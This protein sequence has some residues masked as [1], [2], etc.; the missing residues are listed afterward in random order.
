MIGEDLEF[1]V[2]GSEAYCH[3]AGKLPVKTLFHRDRSPIMGV[4][5]V[6]FL[7]MSIVL[8]LFMN[9]ILFLL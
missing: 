5:S 1:L 8:A 3:Q 9:Q 7:C 4:I 2:D 6:S